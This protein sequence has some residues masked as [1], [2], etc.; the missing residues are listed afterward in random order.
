[1]PLQT[2][3]WAGTASRQQRL[4]LANLARLTPLLDVPFTPHR[5]CFTGYNLST[6][7]SHAVDH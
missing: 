1:M 7:R 6:Q 2:P 5:M 3:C 4:A